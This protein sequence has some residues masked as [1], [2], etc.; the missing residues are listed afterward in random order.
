M[1]TQIIDGYQLA[2]KIQQHLVNELINSNL[3]KKIVV[4]A[5]LFEEDKG[6]QLYT[7]LK[8]EMAESLGIEYQVF[9]FS[10][11]TKFDQVLTQIQQLNRDDNVT[12]IIIQKPWRK[13]WLNAF[14]LTTE[15]G[16][17]KFDYWWR[18]LVCCLTPKKDVDGLHPSNLTA[19]KTG[20]WRAQGR[21]LPATCQATIRLLEQAFQTD[22]LFAYLRN[23]QLKT[24]IL[25]KSDLLGQPLF[26]ILSAK[27]CKVEIIGSQELNQRIEQGNNLKDADVIVTATGRKNLITGDLIKDG[28]VVID[29]GE[30]YGDVDTASV[31]GKARAIT[32]VPG[33]V[34]PMTVISL[35]EN[36][37]YLGKNS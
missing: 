29:V 1:Q 15:E 10:V 13:T 22:Q 28:V 11:K 3:N 34:G 19:I 20:D 35:M 27:K 9:S 4:A 5:I 7:Q 32:P 26:S 37:I 17:D 16:K 21:V 6:S 8:K 24:V 18:Q 14:Q 2:N 31:I 36:A 25:G 23:N 12:G 33:G 30:P